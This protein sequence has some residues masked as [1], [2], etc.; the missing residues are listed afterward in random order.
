MQGF[1]NK[2]GKTASEAASKAGNK[3]NELMEVG[4]LKSRISSKKQDMGL[5]KKEIGDYCYT[6]YE[7]GQIDDDK[8]VAL[9]EKIKSFGAEIEDLERQ[10]EI[11]KDEYK[12]I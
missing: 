8:I 2:V 12:D 3:A 11:A 6:L 4:K 1:F 7:A 5:A 9:C 10:I